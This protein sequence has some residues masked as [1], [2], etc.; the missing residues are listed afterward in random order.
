MLATL[1]AIAESVSQQANLDSALACFVKMVKEAMQTECCSIYF[2][3]YSQ[4]D[5]V[6]MATQGLNPAAVG[7]F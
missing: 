6:L 2:A 7:K 4:D 1:R 5:F 3:D